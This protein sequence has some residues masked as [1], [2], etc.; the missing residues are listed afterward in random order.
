MQA[1]C[2]KCKTEPMPYEKW[3]CFCGNSFNHFENNAKC[4]SCGYTHE[5]TECNNYSCKSIALHLDWYP[6]I[7]ANLK[8][9]TLNL[10]L[11]L[12]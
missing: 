11:I 5:F 7:K 2:P 9:L 6:T 1:C 12:S 8:D 3:D 4:P 10:E